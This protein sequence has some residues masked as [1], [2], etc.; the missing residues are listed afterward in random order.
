MSPLRTVIALVLVSVALTAMAWIVA[1]AHLWNTTADL[2][3]P[4][5]CSALALALLVVAAACV[6]CQQPPASIPLKAVFL[7]YL[8]VVLVFAVGIIVD[9][10]FYYRWAGLR[11]SLAE[12]LGFSV[13]LL[14][15]LW[16]PRLT[17]DEVPSRP[18]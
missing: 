9:A 11:A 4:W 1:T 17:G 2:T 6:I 16:I 14:G 13:I 15:C 5:L 12:W 18:S 10:A 8:G 7:I 3:V